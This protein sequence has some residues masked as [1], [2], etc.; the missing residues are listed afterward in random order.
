MKKEMSRPI[1]A[2][3]WVL[4]PIASVACSIIGYALAVM[5]CDLQNGVFESYSGTNVTSLTKILLYL[6]CNCCSGFLF[7]KA[8]ALTAPEGKRVTAVVLATLHVVI[9]VV[10]FV[11]TTINDF[12]L[13]ETISLVA[14]GAASIITAKSI[15]EEEDTNDTPQIPKKDIQKKENAPVRKPTPYYPIN[16]Q[17]RTPVER[18]M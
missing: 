12:S 4:V 11:T 5:Y 18:K 16:R 9:C 3:R 14:S 13:L 1:K 17:Q 15:Y 6:A 2:L 10:A 7:V 8:G